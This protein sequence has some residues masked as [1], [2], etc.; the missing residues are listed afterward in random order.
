MIHHR[1]RAVALAAI[2]LLSVSA[3]ANQAVEKPAG[4]ANVV[5]AVL[6]GL[7]I[8]IDVR[9]G[10]I[11]KLCLSRSGNHP[12]NGASGKGGTA[13]CGLS[14]GRLRAV[15]ARF[16]LYPN[17]TKVEQTKDAVT[18]TWEKLGGS[19]PFAFPGKVSAVVKVAA[20]ADGRSV[21]LKC[22]IRNQS[23]RAVPQVL[24]PDLHGFL[25]LPGKSET[26]IHSGGFVSATVPRHPTAGRRRILR[27]PRRERR[28][29]SFLQ[30]H[31]RRP[32]VDGRGLISATC[33]AD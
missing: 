27:R 32:H 12:G 2:S 20:D 6:N 8:D 17:R 24:F 10:N 22:T 18:I 31:L 26:K 23:Q 30:K 3:Q 19:R 16:K 28:F 29:G 33:K 25:P 1:T 9:S 15:P 4:A 14:V 7:A 21:T 13:G 11:L 5:H